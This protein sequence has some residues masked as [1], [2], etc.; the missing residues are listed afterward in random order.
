V[1]LQYRET[2]SCGEVAE[3]SHPARE[4]KT[5]IKA[6]TRKLS[7]H[8]QKYVQRPAKYVNWITPFSWSAIQAAQRKVGWSAAAVVAQLRLVNYNFFQHFSENTLRGWIEV[9]GGF[10][11]WTPAVLARA[12]KGNILGHKNRGRCGILVR[13]LRVFITKTYC[14]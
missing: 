1:D 2:A 5:K 10:K 8:K 14:Y 3:A 12:A 11:Q 6:E 9:V 7:G 4:V 13:M